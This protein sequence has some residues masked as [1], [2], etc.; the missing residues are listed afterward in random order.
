MHAGV[1]PTGGPSH[2]AQLSNRPNQEP[3]TASR[4]ARSAGWSAT[5]AWIG[6]PSPSTTETTSSPGCSI[7]TSP[8][9]PDPN[10]PL[11][12]GRPKLHTSY[13][14]AP[15]PGT[16]AANRPSAPGTTMVSGRSPSITRTAARRTLPA[17]GVSP[18]AATT[19]PVTSRAGG[20]PCSMV[21]ARATS[22]TAPARSRP[23]VAMRNRS[24]TSPSP[25]FT[26]VKGVPSADTSV[27]FTPS[28][29]SRSQP[30][31]P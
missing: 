30:T 22:A 4:V 20:S 18:P 31:N 24:S 17:I 28:R 25:G 2:G 26:M 27:S 11:A 16:R 8:A 19:R 9:S 10:E 29:R 1:P 6:A 14:S 7:A 21:L 5:T 13:R 12:T 3:V 23:S 15:V